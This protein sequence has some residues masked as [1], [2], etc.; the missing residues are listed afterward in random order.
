MSRWGQAAAVVDNLLYVSGGKTDQYGSYSYT[1]APTSNDLFTL[2][3]SKSFNPSSPPWAYIS[4]S[5]DSATPQGV[6]LAWHSLAA[7]N[8]SQL[9]MFGGDGGPNSPIVLPSQSNSAQILDIS[10][11]P[12]WASESEGWAGQP[13]R[14]IHQTLASNGGKVYLVGGEKDDGSNAG[15]SD[16]YVFDPTKPQ[17]T[18]LPSNNGPPDIYGHCAVILSD[19]T[20]LVFGGYSASE[21]KMIS[22]STIWTFDTTSPSPSWSTA[23]ISGDSLPPTRRDFACSWLEGDKVIIHGGSDVSFSTSYSD[24]WILD[25][26]KSPMGW[27]SVSALSALGARRDHTAVQVGSQVLFFFGKQGMDCIRN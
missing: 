1:S 18:Q 22:F 21:A 24:G 4:G 27:S 14:R 3:L 26:S 19:G 6:E 16:H 5:Q 9:L 23:T 25:A 2:D 17:F 15:Y 8:T 20:M 10:S 12:K 7:Y 11:T 13:P